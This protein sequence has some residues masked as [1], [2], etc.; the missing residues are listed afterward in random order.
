LLV[1]RFLYSRAYNYTTNAKPFKPLLEALP[2]R[3]RW[4][5]IVI[6]FTQN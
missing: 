3:Y 4:T 1:C 6:N 5:K 2:A